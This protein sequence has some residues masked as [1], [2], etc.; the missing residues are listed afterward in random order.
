MLGEGMRPVLD[1][2][3]VVTL[4]IVR[5]GGDEYSGFVCCRSTQECVYEFIDL[6]GDDSFSEDMAVVA[7]AESLWAEEV[8]HAPFRQDVEDF[9]G[10]FY[11]LLERRCKV[12]DADDEAIGRE[13][14]KQY[15]VA[16]AGKFEDFHARYL[17]F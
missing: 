12:S 15:L 13:M 5:S 1:G 6:A 3:L 10:S 11:G 14:A 17:Q 2:F 9:L 7:I 8:G 4:V 16:M